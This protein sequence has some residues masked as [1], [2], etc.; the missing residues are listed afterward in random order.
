MSFEGIKNEAGAA[1]VKLIDDLNNWISSLI[2]RF[3]RNKENFIWNPKTASNYL[4]EYSQLENYLSIFYSHFENS[5]IY[6]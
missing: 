1:P 5:I 6:F 3:F 4:K 2:S